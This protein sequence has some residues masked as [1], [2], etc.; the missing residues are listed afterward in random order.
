MDLKSTLK[1]NDGNEIPLLGFGVFR[2]AEGEETYQAVIKA[3]DIGYRHLDTAMIYGNEV[4]VGKALYDS[5]LKRQEV[6]VT[7]KL[8][9][10]DVRKG[11]IRSAL[12]ASLARLKLDYIDLYLIHWPAD[13]YVKAYLEMIKLKEE[14]L[15]KSIGVSNFHEHHLNDIFKATDVCPAVDQIECHPHLPQHKLIKFCADK[16]IAVEAWSPLGGQRSQGA[17][18]NDPLI[19]KIADKYGKSGAQVLIRW[20]LQRGVIVLPK[21]VHAQRIEQN[22][23]V[24]DFSLDSEDLEL[25]ETLNN[26]QRYGSDPETFDF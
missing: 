17:L 4:S 26:G 3:L 20:Q 15:I 14:G 6:F 12:E 1:L 2:A 9:N 19:L 24:F 22:A 18:I 25:I 23:Q 11:N 21:S 7:T 8:W 13:G 16:G 10:D 5:G